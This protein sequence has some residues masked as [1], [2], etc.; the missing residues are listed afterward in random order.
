MAERFDDAAEPTD[1]GETPDVAF[2]TRTDFVGVVGAGF[3][4]F[5]G[6]IG[7]R[8][9]LFAGVTLFE[10]EEDCLEA[11]GSF[12]SF[13]E[14]L[15]VLLFLDELPVDFGPDDV[16][17]LSLFFDADLLCGVFWSRLRAVVRSCL[18]GDAIDGSFSVDF[19]MVMLFGEF[20]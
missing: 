7:S 11:D 17:P 1:M 3:T 6:D 13:I 15:G 14:V 18:S 4:C 20:L 19:A 12:V 9:P 2:V 5:L 10:A 8:L 16:V